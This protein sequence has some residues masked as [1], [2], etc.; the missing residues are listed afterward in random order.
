MHIAEESLRNITVRKNKR[1]FRLS[2]TEDHRII[3]FN[4]ETVSPTFP[5]EYYPRIDSG[6]VPVQPSPLINDYE[7]LNEIL[8]RESEQRSV[9]SQDVALERKAQTQEE[10]CKASP[11]KQRKLRSRVKKNVEQ[12]SENSSEIKTCDKRQ[13]TQGTRLNDN[14]NSKTP[15]KEHRVQSSRNISDDASPT[16]SYETIEFQSSPDRND[17][18]SKSESSET[19][20]DPGEDNELAKYN[21][22]VEINLHKDNIPNEERDH[23]SESLLSNITYRRKHQVITDDHDASDRPL[24]NITVRKKHQTL[25]EDVSLQPW[26]NRKYTKSLADIFMDTTIAEATR[27]S[28][29]FEDILDKH[30]YKLVGCSGSEND[31][32]DVIDKSKSRKSDNTDRTNIQSK[33]TSTNTNLESTK[34]KEISKTKNISNHTTNKRTY[35]LRSKILTDSSADSIM[36]NE[37]DVISKINTE[38]TSDTQMNQNNDKRNNNE[39]NQRRSDRGETDRGNIERENEVGRSCDQ[40]NQTDFASEV[41]YLG[42]SKIDENSPSQWSRIGT[43]RKKPPSSRTRPTTPPSQPLLATTPFNQPNQEKP[44][45]VGIKPTNQSMNKHEK[46]KPAIN[47]HSNPI[48]LLN[49]CDIVHVSQTTDKVCKNQSIQTGFPLVETTHQSASSSTVCKSC[50]K[51]TPSRHLGAANYGSVEFSE[52][53]DEDFISNE[54]SRLSGV[55][56]LG[57]ERSERACRK[58]GDV[59]RIMQG[60]V[61]YVDIRLDGSDKSRGVVK[62]LNHLGAHVSKTLNKTVTHVIFYEGSLST[63][64]KA[65]LWH[66]PLVSVEWVNACKTSCL[67]LSSEAFPPVHIEDYFDSIRQNKDELFKTVLRTVAK[68]LDDIVTANVSLAEIEVPL[69]ILVLRKYVTPYEEDSEHIYSLHAI[70]ISLSLDRRRKG[71]LRS[72]LFPHVP[73]TMDSTDSIGDDNSFSPVQLT[74]RCSAPA[75]LWTRDRSKMKRNVS[76]ELQFGDEIDKIR[77][78]L[79]TQRKD[80]E[81][82]DN[83][84]NNQRN[85]QQPNNGDHRADTHRDQR[86]ACVSPPVL[87]PAFRRRPAGKLPT[88]T[89][90]FLTGGPKKR[91]HFQRRSSLPNRRNS[92]RLKGNSPTERRRNQN[93]P[94]QRRLG[95]PKSLASPTQ[96][97]LKTNSPTKKSRRLNNKNRN[98]SDNAD[99]IYDSVKRKHRRNAKHLDK[100]SCDSEYR[101]NGRDQNDNPCKR[102]CHCN[103]KNCDNNQDIDSDFDEHTCDNHNKRNRILSNN[104]PPRHK[105]PKEKSTNQNGDPIKPNGKTPNRKHHKDCNCHIDTIESEVDKVETPR[106]INKEVRTAVGSDK[107]KRMKPKTPHR[108][109]VKDVNSN[110]ESENGAKPLT[111]RPLCGIIPS[112]KLIGSVDW[113]CGS[114]V[115][116]SVEQPLGKPPAKRKIRKRRLYEDL[117]T[118]EDGPLSSVE[119][120]PPK[121]RQLAAENS[122]ARR[123]QLLP[124]DAIFNSQKYSDIYE[125][126]RTEK[127][128]EQAKQDDDS[129]SST[130]YWFVSDTNKKDGEKEQE[131]M[132]PSRSTKPGIVCTGVN[133]KDIKSLYSHITELGHFIVEPKVTSRTT[134]VVV[135]GPKR[136]LN[137]LKGIARGCW[138]VKAE[139]VY[140]SYKVG[141]WLYEQRFELSS[142]SPAIQR[143][144]ME[145]QTFGSLYSLDLLSKHG[146]IFVSKSSTPPRPDLIELIGLCG[147][148]VSATMRDADLIVGGAEKGRDRRGGRPVKEVWLLDCITKCSQLDVDKYR[149]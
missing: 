8:E 112:E 55:K 114:D 106:R 38:P 73:Q 44:N 72:L 3:S 89:P 138:V 12:K 107:R 68:D 71:L 56:R 110:M 27:K 28:K 120:P 20:F 14:P 26:S 104:R 81:A 131:R 75:R 143:C 144:R 82:F 99:N 62:I 88:G 29:S 66:I 42:T 76:K 18:K 140:A 83:D 67:L 132:K 7:E 39:N 141:R 64:E 133:S 125:S 13:Q 34:K 70:E 129:R 105:T 117:S 134:H 91:I 45:P 6:T 121:P 23:S 9:F 93:S 98:D 50:K 15:S 119:K 101:T 16:P 69:S 32:S 115:L 130:S 74:P 102:N 60:V 36:S 128:R 22:Q 40:E 47:H 57:E 80:T 147:G 54:V 127:T 17:E 4:T 33:S 10:M 116:S 100:N 92:G 87:I 139:W 2:T 111:P 94:H 124:I 49:E 31:Q 85:H 84:N 145:R 21:E 149:L 77:S 52:D 11:P 35:F 25:T 136:T 142:F 41:V 96:R 79:G 19:F 95:S 30:N 53:D 118:L 109:N 1:N 37:H 58:V 137:L 86:G 97:R 123:R 48:V 90:R 61:A 113:K 63:V 24:A 51:K 103:S 59:G 122:Q 135:E 65:K 108:L 46:D 146:S 43:R 78:L 126:N 5:Q 148:R